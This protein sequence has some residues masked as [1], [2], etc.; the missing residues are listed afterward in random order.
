MRIISIGVSEKSAF[1]AFQLF[2]NAHEI[3]CVYNQYSQRQTL[4]EVGHIAA[5]Y[6]SALPPTAAP[7]RESVSFS[8]FSRR[9]ACAALPP[10]VYLNSEKLQSPQ[11]VPRTEKQTKKRRTR[12]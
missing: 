8:C 3:Q 2:E 10:L 11:A 7:V 6:L 12:I 4:G 1:K 9:D 5:G